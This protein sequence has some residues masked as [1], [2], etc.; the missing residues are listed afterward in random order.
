MQGIIILIFEVLMIIFYGIF[1]RTD[2]ITTSSVS[3]IDSS[4]F[5]VAGNQHVYRS[6][7]FLELE[8]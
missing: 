1:I 3:S 5:F 2:S 7:C 6:V 4:L 8:E